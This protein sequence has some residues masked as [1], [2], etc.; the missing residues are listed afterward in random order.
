MALL[1]SFYH[2]KGLAFGTPSLPFYHPLPGSARAINGLR[3]S[4][5]L[6]QK[7]YNRTSNTTLENE[8]IG[9]PNVWIGAEATTLSS[10]QNH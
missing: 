5:P 4:V 8:Q 1:L 7:F 10:Y 3:H 2:T 9:L 6:G